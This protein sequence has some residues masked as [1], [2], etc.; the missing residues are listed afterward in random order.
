[1]II[2]KAA[3]RLSRRPPGK[4]GRYA[5][6]GSSWRIGAVGGPWA[7]MG[8]VLILGCS[9]L[10]RALPEIPR[11]DGP[12]RLQVVHPRPGDTVPRAGDYTVFGSAGSRLAKVSVNGRNVTVRANGSFLVRVPVPREASP[13]FA[14]ESTLGEDT[15][16]AVVPVRLASVPE[17][18]IGGGAERSEEYRA[19]PVQQPAETQEG[20]DPDRR[21][22]GRH[23][24][25]GPMGWFL[26]PRTRVVATAEQGA[27]TRVRL[28]S[29]QEI[30]VRSTDL[31]RA[32]A[33]DRILR[34]ASAPR[35]SGTSESVDVVVPVSSRPPFLV[36][37]DVDGFVLTL[38]GVELGVESPSV[39]EVHPDSLIQVV[40][41][42]AVTPE[43]VQLRIRTRTRPFGHR[44]DWANGALVLRVRK[45]PPVQSRTPLAGLVIAV[46]AGHPPGGAI[47]PTGLAE[48]TVTLAVARQLRRDLTRRGAAVVLTRDGAVSVGL[49]ERAR[50]AHQAGAHALV[51]IHVD[52]RPGETDPYPDAGTRTYY[53]NRSS[54]PLARA[55]QSGMVRR[56]GLADRGVSSQEFAVVR[57]PWM[58]SV[59]CEGAV[60]ILPE[61]EAALR[62]PEF[63]A[64]YARGIADGLE[65]FFRS[66]GTGIPRESGRRDR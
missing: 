38:Y 62:N 10:P 48:A 19:F 6:P 63:V 36:E 16:R 53:F 49:D 27:F 29:D 65:D 2:G 45:T 14:V 55:V 28:D 34:R 33:R 30:W 4:S 24:A 37:E 35:V 11:V 18:G 52:S 42:F 23:S 21:I 20:E 40:S 50:R 47:G 3:E 17:M 26:F 41:T 15:A 9:D 58:P 60:L 7:L 32:R 46:D 43:R 31:R 61:H 66:L 8:V 22:V 64:R 54:A 12:L 51:S 44:V 1:M 57:S 5:M 56:L 25:D 59:L 13:F 39:V